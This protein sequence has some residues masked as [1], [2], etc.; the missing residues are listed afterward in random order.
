MSVLPVLTLLIV[1]DGEI[2]DPDRNAHD[3]WANQLVHTGRLVISHNGVFDDWQIY[4][5]N[6]VPKP[7]ELIMGFIRMP[8]GI[9]YRSIVVFLTAFMVVAAVW[10]SAGRGQAGLE[11]ALFLGFNPV[12]LLLAVT[13]SSAVLFLG[14]IFLLQSNNRSGIG[15]VMAS[16]ARPEG[17]IY[18]GYHSL[19]NRKWK[20]LAILAVI[21]AG[22]LVFHRTSCG[23][24]TWAA[25][26][27]RYSVAAMAYPTANP[28]TFFPWA[29]LR[30]VLVLG[31]PVAAVLFLCFRKWQL[32]WPFT[33]NFL[34]LAISLV[35]GSLVL[36]RYV[37]QLFLLAVP[38]VFIEIH[39][40]FNGRIRTA[41]SV[42][43]ILFPSVQWISTVPEIKQYMRLR[44]AYE[45]FE[46]PEQG[47]TAANELL[48]PGFC[49]NLGIDDPS[50]LFVSVDKA[51]WSNAS[52]SSLAERGVTRIVIFD[53]GVYFPEHTARWLETV[54]NIE[55]DY[56]R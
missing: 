26:E 30:L 33:A 12:F 42:A 53:E 14:S 47:L 44:E 27:V 20:L 19:K 39:R 4:Y 8:G 24:F 32:H 23:S 21:A 29:A 46:L 2:P 13:S 25:D 16:L 18:S 43:V 37:D 36:P 11:A 31:A 51:A 17:F 49:L 50:E 7:L 54:E 40:L 9:F 52:E 56:F 48:I 6:T 1:L 35:M 34:L 5:P 45:S 28:V 3:V 38:F 10:N 15:A 22:W 41:V 55:V